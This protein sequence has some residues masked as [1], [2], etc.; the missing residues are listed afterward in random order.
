MTKHLTAD[1]VVN[2]HGTLTA[3]HGMWRVAEN[4]GTRLKLRDAWGNSITC[5]TGSVTV[6]PMPRLTGK[7]ADTLTHLWHSSAGRIADTRTRNWLLANKLIEAADDRSGWY[8]L[9]RLGVIAMDSVS[10]WYR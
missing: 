6:V 5:R 1:P 4:Y 8:R 7:R 10:R 9:T 3:W 2:Y